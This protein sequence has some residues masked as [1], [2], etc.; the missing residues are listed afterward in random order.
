LNVPWIISPR[1][2]L[3]H[4]MPPNT[5]RPIN[6]AMVVERADRLPGRHPPFEPRNPNVR[7][8]ATALRDFDRTYVGLGSK[9]TF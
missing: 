3:I 9:T 5:D 2:K 4:T 7:Q 8:R 1:K 6:R